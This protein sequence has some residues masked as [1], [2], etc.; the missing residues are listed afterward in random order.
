MTEDEMAVLHH[1]LNGLKF[2][3]TPGVVM[4]WEAWCAMVHGL[5]KSWTRLSD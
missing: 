3:H 4:D 5:A 2:E 1:R